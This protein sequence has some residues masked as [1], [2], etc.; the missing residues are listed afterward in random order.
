MRDQPNQCIFI[1]IHTNFEIHST[2][3]KQ[4]EPHFEDDIL[5]KNYKK[6]E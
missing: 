4:D 6:K 2:S 5:K 3:N 1:Y